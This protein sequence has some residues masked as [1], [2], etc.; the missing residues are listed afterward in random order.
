MHIWQQRHIMLGIVLLVTAS[1]GAGD[2]DLAFGDPSAPSFLPL[3]DLDATAVWSTAPWQFVLNQL[4]D[5]DTTAVDADSA[6]RIDFRQVAL[7]WE[8][9]ADERVKALSLEMGSLVEQVLGKRLSL[10]A[11]TNALREAAK[12][13]LNPHKPSPSPE[14]IRS[15]SLPSPSPRGNLLNAHTP[16]SSTSRRTR[17]RAPLGELDANA[18][19][20]PSSPL[21]HARPR[22]KRRKMP[23][24]LPDSDEERDQQ[25]SRARSWYPARSTSSSSPRS[26]S[27]TGTSSQDHGPTSSTAPSSQA[28]PLDVLSYADDEDDV[29]DKL[30]ALQKTTF[31]PPRHLWF[32]ELEVQAPLVELVAVQLASAALYAYRNRATAPCSP[33]SSS[34]RA[35]VLPPAAPPAMLD[36]PSPLERDA[37]VSIFWS[38]AGEFF[39]DNFFSS[40]PPLSLPDYVSLASYSTVL[41]TPTILLPLVHLIHYRFLRLRFALAHGANLDKASRRW[42]DGLE[43]VAKDMEDG[44]ACPCGLPADREGTELV[45]EKV[46]GYTEGFSRAAKARNKREE[47]KAHRAA[48]S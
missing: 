14:P 28:P 41:A 11:S 47:R 33:A 10:Q 20:E 19:S 5:G 22:H 30:D 17:T 9:E 6:R 13:A 1:H 35:L 36:H 26:R 4:A 38:P 16:P 3:D 25:T 7:V 37:L 48:L 29:A 32:D 15:P 12:E 21:Q 24:I 8:D 44:E 34:E 2:L 43:Q 40:H 18:P 45:L 23:V 27:A 31:G 39:V 46:R 42:L